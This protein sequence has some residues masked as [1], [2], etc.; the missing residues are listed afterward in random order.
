MFAKS[1]KTS[2]LLLGIT[3]LLCSKILFFSFNDPEGANLLVV[4]VMALILYVISWITYTFAKSLATPKKLL[5][6]L[7]AQLIAISVLY[8]CL[9]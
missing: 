8:V 1:R 3:A 4:S 9:K 2:L 7:C 6:A 5:L